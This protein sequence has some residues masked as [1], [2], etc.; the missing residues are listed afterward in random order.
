MKDNLNIPT[1]KATGSKTMQFDQR[2][3]ANPHHQSQK[4]SVSST[5][6]SNAGHSSILGR[7]NFRQLI[8]S[9]S[10]TNELANTAKLSG[11]LQA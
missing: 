6:R 4:F 10:E 11:S 1:Q 8:T 9:P 2:E 5:V 3:L 7:Y